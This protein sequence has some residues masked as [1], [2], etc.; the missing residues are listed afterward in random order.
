M[1]S[2][3]PSHVRYRL[4]AFVPQQK[5]KVLPPLTMHSANPASPR[6]VQ[7]DTRNM[8]AEQVGAQ[9]LRPDD[10]AALAKPVRAAHASLLAGTRHGLD[11]EFACLTLGAS[12]DAGLPAIQAAAE[13][14]KQFDSIL[15]IGIGGSS[16]GT[17]A[18][19]HALKPE[20][21]TPGGPHL[22]FVENVDSYHLDHLFKTLTPETTAV[23]CVSKSGGTL[24]T[25]VQYIILR[26]WLNKHLGASRA[27]E[28]QWLI[29]DPDQGWMRQLAK[30]EKIASLPVPPRVGG[31]Y[32]VLT[33]VGL[34]PLA[35]LGV[36]I[37]ELLRGANDMAQRCRRESLAENPALEM[38]VLHF[39]LHRQRDKRISIMMPYINRLRLF[40]DWYCQ[41]WAESLG[42]W[43]RSQ[44]GTQ[45]AG[46]LPVRAMGAI[47]QHSQLQMYL[48]SAHDKMF[49]FINL[50]QWDADIPVPL[51][52]E[53]EEAFPYLR[54]RSLV[55][56]I[57]AEFQA[58]RRVVTE[59]G[60]PNMTVDMP[61]LDAYTLGQLI[62]LYQH[63]TVYAGLLYGV[64]P[65]DQPSVETGKRLAVEL[66]SASR[67]GA[68]QN[69]VHS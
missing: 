68:V 22:Y 35:A 34:L 27:R 48:E 29:T 3:S 36:D 42:K 13:T 63:A 17:K 47:D 24:E 65:L 51:S 9:G 55:D 54:D 37:P 25:V 56:V 14:L 43:D 50:K 64:N 52:A 58:T 8:Y 31:R 69:P 66:L 15:L 32:S 57:H 26:D 19:R 18:I 30:R 39:A 4:F 6:S 33:A 45:P 12:M 62:E 21:E 20:H 11:G 2:P 5:D 7:I 41:L 53:D 46:T 10:L 44:P 40:G 38:A 49:S 67:A 16:L 59:V 1:A 23:V 61:Q 28:H 60:H